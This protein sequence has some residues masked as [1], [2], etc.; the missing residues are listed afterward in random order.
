MAKRSA[1]G[2]GLGAFFG[3]DVVRE[4]EE[5]TDRKGTGKQDNEGKSFENR[6][7]HKSA[8][9]KEISQE[10]RGKCFT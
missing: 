2:K 10:T 1:L 7:V 8:P 3:E 5:S 9:Q 4:S 6:S